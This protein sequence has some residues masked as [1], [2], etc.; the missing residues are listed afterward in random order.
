MKNLKS[1]GIFLITFILISINLAQASYPSVSVCTFI[2]K[3]SKPEL[4][5]FY[6]VS[7]LF[8]DVMT[9]IDSLTLLEISAFAG[10]P[11]TY[12]LAKDSDVK[13]EMKSEVDGFSKYIIHSVRDD[14]FKFYFYGIPDQFFGMKEVSILKMVYQGKEISKMKGTCQLLPISN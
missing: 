12:L 9:K 3:N 7:I 6:Q 11:Q 8:N 10:V 2:A 1:L 4:K 14:E 13:A 5:K